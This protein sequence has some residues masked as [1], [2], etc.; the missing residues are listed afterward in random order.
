[1]FVSKKLSL[2]MILVSL[3]FAGTYV[4]HA[5]ELNEVVVDDEN[6]D[7]KGKKEELSE[8][9]DEPEITRLEQALR[10]LRI[11]DT[12][13]EITDLDYD[14]ARRYLAQF[15]EIINFYTLGVIE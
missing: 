10:C 2:L 8:I 3:N 5:M 1:M 11:K 13:Q 12:P 4:A 9:K 14:F 7:E 15:D 6:K